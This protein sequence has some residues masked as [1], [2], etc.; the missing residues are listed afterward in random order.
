[1]TRL[2]NPLG[3]LAATAVLLALHLWGRHELHILKGDSR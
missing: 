3:V 2:L 1:V